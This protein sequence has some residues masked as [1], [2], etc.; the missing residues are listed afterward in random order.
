LLIILTPL[1]VVDAPLANA[2]TSY[3]PAD[4]MSDSIFTDTSTMSQA[5][6]QSFLA[7]ENSG[8]QNYSDIENCSTIKQPYSGTYYPHCGSSVSAATIIYD[9]SQAYGINPRVILATLEKE[10]SLITTPDPTQSQLNC[11]MGYN[12][13]SGF[14]GFFYQVDNGTW[15]FK[16]DMELMSG[17]SWWGL[18][19]S[20]YLCKSSTSLYS[21]GLYPG[22]SVTFADPAQYDGQGNLIHAATP[23]TLTLGSSATA[24][25]YCYTPYVGPISQTGYSGSYNFVYYFELWFGSVLGPCYD[26]SNLSTT[27]GAG[28]VRYPVATGGPD[29]LALTLDNNTGSACAEIHV[30]SPGYQSFVNDYATNLPAFDPTTGQIISSDNLYG[31]G[32]SKLIFVKYANTGSGNIEIHIWGQNYYEFDNEYV[33]NLPSAS[34]TVGQ[35]IAGDFYG[36]GQEELAYVKYQN[37]GSGKVE[38]H[39]WNSNFSGFLN[40]YATNVSENPPTI[41]QVITANLNGSGA[42]SVIY[43]VYQNSSS[44]KIEVHVWNPGYQSFRNDYATNVSVNPPNIGQVFAADIYNAGK[45]NLIYGLLEGGGSGKAEIHI[46]NSNFSGFLNDYA[47]NVSAFTNN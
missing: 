3:N 24:A 31:N 37:T 45:D 17:Q 22:N 40:D 6:I 14:V 32:Q 23:I 21:A 10:Q 42:N 13:C 25:L 18:S 12:S 38:I 4:L 44:G 39:I 34:P 26:S 2:D 16:S 36:N 8:L 43:V 28:I 1:M 41:G 33:T 20:S 46:W 15:Q 5:A 47:T 30:W 35:V 27:T 7:A 11:A 29:S 19:P 9:A